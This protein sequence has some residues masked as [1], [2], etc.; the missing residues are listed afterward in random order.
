MTR[1]L[2]AAARVEDRTPTPVE[3]TPTDGLAV[4][5]DRS[6]WGPLTWFR[7]IPVEVVTAVPIGTP[8]PPPGLAAFPEPGQI[9]ASPEFAA[10]HA[11]DPLFAARYPGEVVATIAPVG[12]AGPN[13]LFAWVA[14][15]EAS[16]TNATSGYGL[17]PEA[18]AQEQTADLVVPLGVL[19]FVL[20]VLILFGTST[21]LGSAQRDQRMAAMRL[22]GAT[23]GEVRLVSA[24]EAGA[25][26]VLGV[27]GGVLLFPGPATAGR[28][29]AVAPG[30]VPHRPGP[31]AGPGGA[32]TVALPLLGVVA[33][34][35]SQRRVVT[36]PL[37]V[38]RRATPRP[39]RPWRL[40]PLAVGLGLLLVLLVFPSL[41]NADPAIVYVLLLG[42]AGLTLLGL[43]LATPLVGALAAPGPAAPA[44]PAGRR[45]AGR[46]PGAGRPDVGG[47]AG[48]RRH[49]A[50]VHRH[51]DPGRVPAR[52]RAG[53]HRLHAPAAGRRSPRAPSPGSPASTRSPH[54]RPPS[55]CGR[56]AHPRRRT[57]PD[58]RGGRRLDRCS[59]HRRLRRARR[60]AARA[61]AA[62]PARDR[63]HDQHR[64]HHGARPPRR[65]H[66]QAHP[67]PAPVSHVGAPRGPTGRSA[68]P[69]AAS[70]SGTTCCPPT[71]PRRPCPRTG[72]CRASSPPT[73]TRTPSR[74]SRRSW[75]PR[76]A[77]SR[78]PPRTSAGRLHR[79][80]ACT[81]LLLVAYLAAIALIA[82][83]SLAVAGADD[84]RTRA[85][86]MAGLAAAGTP[87]GTLRRASLIQL[88]LTLIP[89]GRPGPG[90]GH[91][92]RVHVL[93]AV[94]RRLVTWNAPPV[95]PQ[96]HRRRRNRRRAH[97][98][99]RLRADPAHP[100]H[101]RRPTQPPHH[102]TTPRQK[103]RI[104]R[105]LKVPS[106]VGQC[107]G[108]ATFPASGRD[109]SVAY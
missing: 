63:V 94:A 99:D 78:P 95:R 6:G 55:A 75:P 81:R 69:C 20:P 102:L 7:G 5:G 56:R 52:A 16:G 13:E 92:R 90:H 66:R 42:G 11:T 96:R 25:I 97:R 50:D 93:P 17:A 46:P 49:G 27:V 22:V 89:G 59:G 51:L 57:H 82:M 108:V 31:T 65:P 24:A 86:S 4:V 10:L 106:P 87:V 33:G 2:R 67:R 41:V 74:P 64:P 73:A 84:L 48:H 80:A 40:I 103:G 44:A 47:P 53:Q 3:V 109:L 9:A 107:P 38:T 19:L 28:A 101:H 15:A 91:H 35:V 8:P 21:R 60:R 26:G 70:A 30:A 100:A 83:V 14:V 72:P 18:R 88:A 45:R 68:T 104:R 62:V 71:T 54:C 85:R 79:P 58:Q 36:S 76:P 105:S 12:L 1:P 37:G 77:R 23:P 34:Y 29:A 39:P 98:A 32:L 61:A 43:V